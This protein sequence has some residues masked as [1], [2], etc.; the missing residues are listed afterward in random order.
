MIF[1]IGDVLKDRYRITRRLKE[2]PAYFFWLAK[3]EILDRQ[4]SIRVR[5]P[6]TNAV[7]VGTFLKEAQSLARLEHPHLLS[8]Y[9]YGEHKNI[10]F[11]VTQYIAGG[12]LD[13]HLRRNE[14]S[15]LAVLRL[16]NHLANVIDF[17]H[18]QQIVHGDINT[19]NI[20]LDKYLHPYISNLF[21]DSSRYVTKLK[22]VYDAADERIIGMLQYMAPETHYDQE[23]SHFSDLYAFG[24]T[25]YQCFTGQV[26]LH[27]NEP[28]G[29]AQLREQVDS[30]PSVLDNQRELPI[31]VDVV[32]Q[33]LTRKKPT[34]RYATATEA[35]S[36]LNKAFYSE[37]KNVDG[38]I[39][40][41]Y[42]RADKEYVYTLAREMRQ[43]GLNL[44]IDQ[45]IAPGANWD[46]SIESALATSDMLLL[47]ASPASMA[48]NNV[49]DEWSYYL[50]EDK[51]VYTFIYEECDLS[52]RLR[53]RQYVTSTGDLLN[54]IAK[55]VDMLA[56][57]TPSTT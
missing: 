49:Q 16:A 15:S 45:D 17:L 4:V 38:K 20:F 35:I 31:S 28:F 5:R 41:S 52:F 24:I 40:I 21:L 30:L 23:L 48:S 44:W 8:I 10:Q 22:K 18:D 50:D 9:D 26:P 39:F 37:Q 53:R 27:N 1:Q 36:A 3:D 11:L 12:S 33:R 43:V 13:A 7:M 25:L 56:G 57:G 55:I 42:A 34:E 2:S 46:S 19:H 29:L 32:L 6:H 14:L 51:P 47:I 54:D